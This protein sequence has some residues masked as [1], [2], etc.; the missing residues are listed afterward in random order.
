MPYYITKT[1]LDAFDAARTWGL[2]VVL[3]VLT[4]DE[5][6]IRNVEW[7]FVVDSAV[8][9]PADLAIANNLAP[10]NSNARSPVLGGCGCGEL[11]PIIVR[12]KAYCPERLPRAL[13]FLPPLVCGTLYRCPGVLQSAESVKPRREGIDAMELLEHHEPTPPRAHTGASHCGS[14]DWL[15]G[16]GTA[17]RCG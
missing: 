1:G 5:V 16:D 6:E 17:T 3:N 15:G 2:A 13:C 10:R 14:G 12:Q 11:Q 7:A 8:P 4:E 9:L